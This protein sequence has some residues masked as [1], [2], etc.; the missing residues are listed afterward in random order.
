MKE[1]IVLIN[2]II[3]LEGGY[4]NDL[5]DH[6]G[7]TKYGITLKSLEDWRGHKVINDDVFD[8]ELEEA[9]NIYESEY[10]LKPKINLLPELLRP[11]VFDMGVN[12]GPGTAIKVMQ[13]VIHKIGT[14]VKVDGVIGPM[15]AQSAKTAC[16]LCP[17]I[18]MEIADARIEHYRSIV[19]KD[20]SQGKFLNGWINRANHFRYPVKLS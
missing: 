14:P 2:E 9:F 7:A 12:Y 1:I 13:S 19:D 4:V 11:A 16:N 10:Y 5:H 6:G 3:K 20:P 17:E 8:L 15:T 18:L